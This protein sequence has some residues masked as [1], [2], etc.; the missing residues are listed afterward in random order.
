MSRK[1]DARRQGVKTQMRQ[2]WLVNHTSKLRSYMVYPTAGIHFKYDYSITL[3]SADGI[4]WRAGTFRTR[5][6]CP[7][8]NNQFN[9]AH[10]SRCNLLGGLTVAANLEQS[11]EFKESTT[12]MTRLYR[13]KEPNTPFH[14]TILDYLLNFEN[15]RNQAIFQECIS[16]L[17]TRLSPVVPPAGTQTV[18]PDETQISC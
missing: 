11:Y 7:G 6:T 14:Y 4:R 3:P 12:T 2:E 5:S 18:P 10:I 8:C 9:R 15:P 1:K 13:L 16:F 17:K